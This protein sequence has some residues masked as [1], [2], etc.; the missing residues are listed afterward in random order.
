M[1][2]GRILSCVPPASLPKSLHHIPGGMLLPLFYSSGDGSRGEMTV[3]WCPHPVTPETRDPL[4]EGFVFLA[5]DVQLRPRRGGGAEGDSCAALGQCWT[6]SGIRTRQLPRPSAGGL[7]AS[8]T[9]SPRVP[10]RAEVPITAVGLVARPPC[11]S[12]SPESC[13]HPPRGAS[14]NRLTTTA[15]RS[16]L[17]EPK[18]R[19]C[20]SRAHPWS[21]Q[22]QVLSSDPR[23]ASAL[24]GYVHD[25]PVCSPH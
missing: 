9:Q 18:P 19:Q 16:A 23:N 6:V 22:A 8:P 12:P 15:L 17:R 4:S 7:P 10:S 5:V 21:I 3:L 24:W 13:P 20:W 14:R 2:V 25:S 1:L 11:S